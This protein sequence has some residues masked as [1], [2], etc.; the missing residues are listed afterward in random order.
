VR[1]Q[2]TKRHTKV[3]DL[4][5]SKITR[6]RGHGAGGKRLHCLA[7]CVMP[8]LQKHFFDIGELERFSRGPWWPRSA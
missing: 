7:L 5:R 2:P 4:A 6:P 3:F 8:H 1:K